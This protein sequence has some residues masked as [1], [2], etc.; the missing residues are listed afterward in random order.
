M[1]LTILITLFVIVI[2]NTI[3][4]NHLRREIL[5]LVSVVDV[6]KYCY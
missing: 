1:D 6:T 5:G 4:N 2:I 3:S